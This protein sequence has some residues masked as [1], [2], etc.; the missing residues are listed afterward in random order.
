LSID[1]IPC[2]LGLGERYKLAINQGKF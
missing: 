1:V 2:G